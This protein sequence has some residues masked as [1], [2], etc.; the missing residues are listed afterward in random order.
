ML[1][2]FLI[3]LLVYVAARVVWRLLGGVFEGL[4]Y[5]RPGNTPQSV[6]L[7]RDPVC[8]TFVLPSK[9]LTSGSGSNTR[10]FCS[11]KCRQDYSHRGNAEDTRNRRA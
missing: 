2:V 4:G 8:G 5:Q 11:E 10:Y 3:I 1:R 7:V 6:G 9:A